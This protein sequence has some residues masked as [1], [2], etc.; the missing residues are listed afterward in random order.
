MA[1]KPPPRL[2]LDVSRGQAPTTPQLTEAGVR[3][4]GARAVPVD[5]VVPDP[6]QPRQDWAH[7]DG[8]RRLDELVA[9]IRQFGVLQPLLVREDGALD[10]GRM[11]YTIIA[12]G[13]RREAAARAG[14][15]TIPVIVRDEESERVRV[16]Q[17]VEN[18]QRQDLSPLD[19]ARAYQELMD[20]ERI[21]AEALG[22]RLGI[23]GQQ[24]RDR[25]LLLSDQV[26][27]DAVQRQQVP[28]SIAS[29]M[30][31]LS[32]EGRQQLRTRLE[33][34]DRLERS[35]VRKV[36]E[37]TRAA[38]VYNSR[39]KGGGRAARTVHTEAPELAAPVIG[40]T[41]DVPKDQ[42][43][44][45]NAVIPGGVLVALKALDHVAL[46]TL[47]HYGIGRQWTCEELWQAIRELRV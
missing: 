30:L 33:L 16:L 19:E 2:S 20:T 45:D 23:S 46:E 15:A 14:L 35:D 21:S 34:G 7:G 5:Q 27:S 32:D 6:K 39:A 40:A 9:S 26:V 8:L 4:V 22:K 24:V 18:I 17:L 31:R 10:D 43:N 11:R 3:L 1:R 12:G 36:R 41:D 28:A 44:F 42:R 25:V 37:Q 38:G 13:R 47:L 29:E